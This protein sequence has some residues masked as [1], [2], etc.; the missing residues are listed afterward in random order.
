M[1]DLSGLVTPEEFRKLC[2][3][4][5]R[6][7]DE[8]RQVNRV[9]QLVKET[10]NQGNANCIHEFQV[11]LP[12]EIIEEFAKKGYLIQQGFDDLYYYIDI[13]PMTELN[14]AQ[15]IYHKKLHKLW[16]KNAP[17]S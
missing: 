17:E 10:I 2:D 14:L 4:K 3:Q 1:V 6:K 13:I 12:E 15:K 11:A 8:A 16:I 5:N 7:K 9:V